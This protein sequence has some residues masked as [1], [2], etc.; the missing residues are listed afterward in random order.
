MKRLLTFLLLIIAINMVVSAQDT[1]PNTFV[2][3]TT[4]GEDVEL[5]TD[6]IDSVFVSGQGVDA[7][8]HVRMRNHTLRTYV[9]D[10]ISHM[11]FTYTAP[12]R[13]Q[14]VDLGLSVEWATC[15]VGGRNPEDHGYYFSWGETKIKSDYSENNYSWFS[16]NAYQNIGSDICGTPNDAATII[17]GNGWRMPSFTDVQELMG[18]CTWTPDTVNTV[19]G[20]TITGPSGNSIFLPAAGYKSVKKIV[21]R[22]TGGYY[23]TGTI[24]PTLPS[25]AY[26]IN[27]RGY[28]TPW[29]A[30]RALGFTIRAV[31]E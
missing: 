11:D 10:E 15:N 2:L 16:D 4:T 12:A 19:P 6:A 18:R 14:S 31:R 7:M 29:T 26:T 25:S 24:S 20:Y 21:D 23:W 9:L 28:D 22:G 8:L 1:T 30:N 5:N 17:C 13:Y 27:F 3:H